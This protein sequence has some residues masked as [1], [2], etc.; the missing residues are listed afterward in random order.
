MVG[1][2]LGV[3]QDF[4]E[5][6]RF[7][8]LC[9]AGGAATTSREPT[10]LGIVDFIQAGI[11]KKTPSLAGVKLLAG[12][13]ERFQGPVHLEVNWASE[14][15]IAAAEQAGGQVTSIHLN[16]LA[17]RAL[18]CPDK[19][20]KIAINK[21]D[22]ND[23][24]DGERYVLPRQA[25]PPPKLQPYYTSWKNRG[26]L[27]PQVQMREYLVDSPGLEDAFKKSLKISEEKSK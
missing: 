27:C 12:G 9:S 25:R 2:N 20:A 4:I 11:F 6:G 1:L 21:D 14:E 24:T 8:K 5:M 3:I 18:V 17:V 26:Y 7:A 19:F 13:K 15:A 16:R 23:N 10:T 22:E